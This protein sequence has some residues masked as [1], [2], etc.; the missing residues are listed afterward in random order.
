MVG[1]LI[2]AGVVLLAVFVM[3]EITRSPRA[4]LRLRRWVLAAA[5][6]MYSVRREVIQRARLVGRYA[7]RLL[8]PHA[9]R[10]RRGLEPVVQRTGELAE[11][12]RPLLTRIKTGVEY[13]RPL[14][15][16]PAA[17]AGRPK[18][19]RVSV[20]ALFTDPAGQPEPRGDL[21]NPKGNNAR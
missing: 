2:T 9:S 1:I 20:G 10:A 3:H 19:R 12:T 11:R 13:V 5:T 21:P 7:R 4:R 6:F 16:P 14:A 15:P 17:R 18:A 8:A